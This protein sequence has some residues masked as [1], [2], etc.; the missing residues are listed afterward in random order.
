[1]DLTRRSLIRRAATA[2]GVL[3]GGSLLGP[4]VVFA[5]E[6]GERVWELS[7]S[8]S[9]TVVD[10]RRTFEMIGIRG[11]GPGAE[12]R[13]RGLDGRWSEWLPVHDGHDHG[14]DGAGASG[15]SDPIW[16]G[17]ARAFELR[18][19][20]PLRGAKA[21]L[22]DAGGA[23]SAAAIRYVDSG[24]TAGGGQPDII[25]RSSW[26]TAACRPRVPS[27][28]GAIDLAFV[29]HTVSTNAYQPS[30]SVRMVRS[31]CLFHKYG[32][33]WND[34]GYNFVVD[35]YGR[36]FEGRAGGIDE[37][38]VGA[39]A[40]GY[41]DYSTGVALLGTFTS[42]GPPRSA[43][44]SLAQLLAWKL[45]LHGLEIP[46]QVTV[47]V[48]R[49]GAPYSRYRAGSLVTLNRIAGHRDADSTSCPGAGMYRQLPR[50]RQSVRALAGPVAALSDALQASAPGSVTV[51]GVLTQVG[52][53]IAGAAIEVQSRS[54]TRGPTTLA[55]AVTD[56]TGAWSAT[57]PVG[58]PLLLRAVY[59]GSPSEYPAVVS[60]G[61]L[62]TAP[63]VLTLA[64]ATQQ[65]GPGSVIP[66][67]GSVTPAKPRVTIVVAQQQAD[68]TLVT[69]RTIQLG[70]AADGTFTRSIGFL[71]AGQ[72]Q[73]VAHTGADDLNALGTSPAVAITIA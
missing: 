46:G 6:A 63:P 62:A 66:F 58:K 22:V 14:P 70:P 3:L 32:N 49:S 17:P 20:R 72:Y 73:V 15:V 47:K 54:T 36:V 41:N 26:A 9:A 48:L 10:S 39:Q 30:Q 45:S 25:A 53:P 5:G 59:R 21:V 68:G 37:A 51:G 13:A 11:A 42:G 38:I 2:S 57:V 44:E 4:R 18:S 50:L 24:L 31:I 56:A 69:V 12:L 16:T 40:G 28:F 65:A 71:D 60:T 64:A 8:R 55:T 52:L 29:H 7:I 27:V 33:G 34:I 61:V 1:M 43:F 35:R 67:T 19:A 23:A